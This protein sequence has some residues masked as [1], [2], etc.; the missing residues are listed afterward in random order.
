[1]GSNSNTVQFHYEF[2][3][4][5]HLLGFFSSEVGLDFEKGDRWVILNKCL[6]GKYALTMLFSNYKK[7]VNR[8]VF[9]TDYRIPIS[10]TSH[11]HIGRLIN[12]IE[13]ERYWAN[14]NVYLEKMFCYKLYTHIDCSVMKHD[15]VD[16][17]S[18]ALL[19]E[20]YRDS[21]LQTQKRLSKVFKNVYKQQT[22]KEAIL[23]FM[24]KYGIDEDHISYDALER[25]HKRFKASGQQNLTYSYGNIRTG[26]SNELRMHSLN[27]YRS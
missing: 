27:T 2:P 10:I 14:F 8:T 18:K 23:E 4:R 22:R 19:L 12:N 26:T 3:I 25:R 1:M 20:F 7:I 21:D 15:K 13:D 11:Y 16:Q 5:P 9:E 6:Y 17:L 24:D